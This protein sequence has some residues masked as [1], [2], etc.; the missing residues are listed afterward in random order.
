MISFKTQIALLYLG[1][2]VN[3]VQLKYG[4]SS[5]YMPQAYSMAGPS[6]TC[7][8]T[9]I[10]SCQTT[11]MT[12]CTTRPMTRCY[13]KKI[14]TIQNIPQPIH[15]TTIVQAPKQE[16]PQIHVVQLERKVPE[17][18]P[19]CAQK[20]CIDTVELSDERR[21]ETDKPAFPQPP[22]PPVVGVTPDEF[23][24][25]RN[26]VGAL[27]KALQ[28]LNSKFNEHGITMD[29][30][31]QVLLENMKNLEQRVFTN[32][33][34]INAN[35]D[36]IKALRDEI[37]LMKQQLDVQVGNLKGQLKGLSQKDFSGVLGAL[38]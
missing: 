27:K 30:K 16:A 37:D 1:A 20:E 4:C 3:G 24:L 33:K 14:Q 23:G 22:A 9:P 29:Q 8:S 19:P 12:S 5:G 35:R 11:P 15:H 38:E 21:K 28:D 2:T 31:L 6:T 25:L 13:S 18:K 34:G 36:N 7:T 17:C 10:T 26:E 32:E